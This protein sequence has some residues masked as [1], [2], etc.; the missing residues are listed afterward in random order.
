MQVDADR[1]RGEYLR[2]GFLHVDVRPRVERKGDASTVFYTI[3]EGIRARTKV[4]VNGLANDPDLTVAKVREKLPL[5][6]GQNFDYETYDLAKEPLKAVAQ[7]A[8]YA[9]ARLDSTV[10]AD[11]ANHTAIVELDYTLGPK[12]KF[13]EAEVTG[14]TGRLAEAVRARLEFQPG[15]QYSNSAIAATQRNLYGFNRFSTVQ[16]Q[17]S[18]EDATNAT[19]RMKVAVSEAARHEIKLGGGFGVDP[20]AFE[21]RGRAGYSIAGW[22]FTMDTASVDLRPAYARLRDGSGYQPRIRAMAKLERQDI[23]WTYSKGEV[24]GGYNYLAYEAFTSYGP[25]ARLGFSTPIGTERLQFRAGWGIELLAFRNISPLIDESLQMSLGIDDTQRIGQYEQT[26]SLD[27]RDHP[28]QPRFGAYAG[29]ALPRAHGSPAA[30]SSSSSSSP[31][32]EATFRWAVWCSRRA[33]VPGRSSVTYPQPSD[34]S[35]AAAPT[36]AGSASAS[37]RRS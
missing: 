1:V 15:Q 24:E 10:Y 18:E 5:A 13:G 9:H 4:V 28:I 37:C 8:G 2:K 32:C 3:E 31:S 34:S 33:P 14:V 25:R 29:C 27:L 12:A 11:R 16:V 23:F 7:D 36:T 19:V 6:D 35:R 21:V 22:P 17:P 30:R 20:T 26:L